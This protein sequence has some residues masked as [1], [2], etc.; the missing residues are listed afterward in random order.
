MAARVL[1]VD[2]E[3]ELLRALLVRFKA[4]GFICETANDGQEALEKVGTQRPDI[5]IADLVMPRMDGYELCRRLKAN[6]QTASIPVVLLTA[7]PGYA[8]DQDIT[9][10]G[11]SHVMHKPF[12][13]AELL[14]VVRELMAGPT[15]G[16]PS[17][18]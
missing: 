16:G 10:L 3:P 15:P 13:S 2:D 12:D 17:H 8:F 6:A 18:G 9:S 11:A 7:V 4:S 14:S 5:V 1:V